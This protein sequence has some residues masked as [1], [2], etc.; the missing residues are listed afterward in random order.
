MQSIGQASRKGGEKFNQAT[1]TKE[2]DMTSTNDIRN[3]VITAV[4]AILASALCFSTVVP[5][6]YAA[7]ATTSPAAVMLPLA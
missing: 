4:C 1:R 6:A 3:T 7:T 2:F 5:P